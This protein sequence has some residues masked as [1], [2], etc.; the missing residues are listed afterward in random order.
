MSDT[1]SASLVKTLRDRTSAGMMECKRAL[2]ETKGDIEAAVELLRKSGQA[3]ADKKTAVAAEGV[4][5]GL[6]SPDKKQGLLIEVNCQTDFVARDNSFL[7]FAQSVAEKALESKTSD[8]ESLLTQKLTPTETIDEARRALVATIGENIQIR[9]LSYIQAKNA[10][11]VYS[12]NGRIGSIV[13]IEGGDE[14]LGKDIAMHIVASQPLVVN[15]SEI[16][17]DLINKEKEIFSA[18]AAASG[19]PANII[20][21]MVEGRIQKFLGEVSL[22][23][24]P[25]V[26]NPDETVGKLLEKSHAKVNSFVRYAVGEG[27]EKKEENFAEEVMAQVR[28]S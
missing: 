8:P 16:S 2:T 24:Q 18:Q 7:K 5:L 26:K 23:G 25:F 15:P 4:I 17:Q 12:H 19:K 21:K 11:T 6:I 1:I 14:D 13:D 27:I 28:G 10:L 20:E 9:R 3:K 22:L